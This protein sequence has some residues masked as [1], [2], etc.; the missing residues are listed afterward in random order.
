[1]TAQDVVDLVAVLHGE[2]KARESIR[3]TRT[4]LAM[5]LDH[6]RINPNPARDPSVKLPREEPEEVQPPSAD[7]VA[8]VYRLVP[9]KHRLALLWLDWSGAR[10]ASVDHV[11]VGDYDESRRRVRLRAATTKT[12]GALWV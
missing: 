9:A 3:K 2:G 7:D 5:V 11:L 6:E 4:A 12:R 10:V 1:M 8:T